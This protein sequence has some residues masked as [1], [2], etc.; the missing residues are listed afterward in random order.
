MFVSTFFNRHV[1]IIIISAALRLPRGTSA[2]ERQIW[3]ESVLVMLELTPL[4][5]T[6]VGSE[7]AGGMSFEQKKR[8]SIGIGFLVIIH[9]FFVSTYID[10]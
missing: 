9:A 10:Y 1:V 6:L 8:V 4:E 2:E 5:N 7:M 3:V